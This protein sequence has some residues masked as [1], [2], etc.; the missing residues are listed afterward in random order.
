MFDQLIRFLSP[1]RGGHEEWGRSEAPTPTD[2]ILRG[3][4]QRVGASEGGRQAGRPVVRPKPASSASRVAAH[5]RPCGAKAGARA[6]AVMPSATLRRTGAARAADQLLGRCTLHVPSARRPLAAC[7]E[8]PPTAAA[9]PRGRGERA[10]RTGG[11]V[12]NDAEEPGALVPV[13]DERGRPRLRAEVLGGVQVGR[14]LPFLLGEHLRHARGEGRLSAREPGEGQTTYCAARP[15]ACA[16]AA[17]QAG[18]TT[19]GAS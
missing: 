9:T 4:G 1:S 8:L 16:R 3:W 7:Q 19:Q 14:V 2:P 13:V 5:N 12:G 6:A 10:R 15:R 17:V 18:G 11:D